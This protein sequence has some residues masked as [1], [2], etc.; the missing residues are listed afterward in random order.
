MPADPQRPIEAE[1]PAV[2]RPPRALADEIAATLRREILDGVHLP[3]DKLPT[4]SALSRRFGVA[5][6]TL[7]TAL[8][9][10]LGANLIRV[11]QGSGYFVR[12]FHHDAGPL[13]L[14]DL[15]QVAG[16]QGHLPAVAADLLRVRRHLAM[17]VV[18]VLREEQPDLEPCRLAVANFRVAASHDASPA[19][20][21][22]ADAAI[23][24][25]LLDATG[26]TVLQLCFNPVR[27]VLAS[28]PRLCAALYAEPAANAAGWEALLA[29]LG[30]PD[31][32]PSVLLE[33]LEQRDAHTL[34]TL[35][36]S[37]AE[38]AS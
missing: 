15:T 5:K 8:H 9:Q 35:Q 34:A 37:L 13:L 23:V 7:R 6:P 2:E 24:H 27:M 28:S 22:R 32:E 36:A 30:Q 17:A 38:E 12:S 14:A 3:G 31:G 16:E 20:L 1:D 10:L 25:A 21:A 18:E 33:L 11:R 19:A 26:S 4:E 29:W